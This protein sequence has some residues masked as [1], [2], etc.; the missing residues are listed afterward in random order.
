MNIMYFLAGLFSGL[1]V[2]AFFLGKKLYHYYI[3]NKIQKKQLDR[4]LKL[5]D[6][7]KKTKFQ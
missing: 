3:I 2:I 5:N 4:M 1:S 7:L 6:K